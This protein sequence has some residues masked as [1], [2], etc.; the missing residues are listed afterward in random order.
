MAKKKS[1]QRKNQALVSKKKKKKRQ[2]QNVAAH[3]RASTPTVALHTEINDGVDYV[4]FAVITEK[5]APLA[6]FEPCD[7]SVRLCLDEIWDEV[8]HNEFINPEGVLIAKICDV[9]GHELSHKWFVWG[10]GDEFT[11]SFNEQDE[12]V[13][14]LC[15]D[16]VY[17][18]KMTKIVEYDWK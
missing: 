1:N 14:R 8:S 15:S 10:M 3:K 5:G 2:T 18:S 7:G 11:E 12:R 17:F 16:W 9:L 4:R 6:D 13:M